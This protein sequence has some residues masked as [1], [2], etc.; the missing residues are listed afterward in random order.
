MDRNTYNDE[1][2]DLIREKTD[3]YKMYPS[4]RVWKEVYG[5]LHAKRRRFVFGMT[6]LISGI[7]MMAGKELLFPSR[8][9]ESFR[10]ITISDLPKNTDPADISLPFSTLKKS[11]VVQQVAKRE[12]EVLQSGGGG[13]LAIPSDV[14]SLLNPLISLMNLQPEN[15]NLLNSPGESGVSGQ[16]SIIHP[17]DLAGSSA[18]SGITSSLEPVVPLPANLSDEEA[19]ARLQKPETDA[20]R[21]DRKQI[22][23]LQQYAISPMTPPVQQR[24]YWQM[25]FTPTVNYRTLTGPD[26]PDIKPSIPNVPVAVLHFGN[27]NNF[28]DH[29]PAVGF[30]AGTGLMYRLTRNITLKAGMQFNY[31]RYYIKAY[32]SG[33]QSAT[34][35]LNSYYGY[36]TDSLT[37]TIGNFAGNSRTS[38]QNKFYQIAAPIGMEVRVIGNGRLQFHIGGTIEPNYLL[39]TNSYLLTNDYTKYIKEPNLMRRW[40]VNAGLEAFVSYQVGGLRWQIGPQFGYQLYSTYKN[41]YPVKENLKEYGIKISVSKILH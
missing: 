31:S 33:R 26:Y 11:S 16:V 38:V 29:S 30:Q 10:K 5:A 27:V 23:W 19:A 6:V 4:N 37:T 2:E 34:L 3:H 39:N 21:E 12:L 14:A 41:Q 32:T 15:K 25:W 36:I 9:T 18:A 40:N 7:L 28:V 8:H 24:V 22:N 1:F 20:D 35:T 13:S 17:V